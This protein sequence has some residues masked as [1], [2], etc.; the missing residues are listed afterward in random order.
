MTDNEKEIL[1]KEICTGLPFGTRYFVQ[2]NENPQI[3]SKNEKISYDMLGVYVRLVKEGTHIVKPYLKPLSSM[4]DDEK[5]E[6]WVAIDKDMDIIEDNLDAPT[7]HTYN[8]RVYRGNL[9]HYEEDFLK[10]NHFDYRGLIPM[11]LAIKVTD[12]NNPYKDEITQ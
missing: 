2:S 4:T 12:E 8:G 11:G 6:L 10:A 9:I 7:I 5:K 3:L 1:I